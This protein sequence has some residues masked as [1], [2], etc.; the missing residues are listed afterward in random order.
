MYHSF[1][2]TYV[3][4][5]V[6]YSPLHLYLVTPDFVYLTLVPS[7]V[8]YKCH[9]G[10]F[11]AF[12]GHFLHSLFPLFMHFTLCFPLLL[13]CLF[14]HIWSISLSNLILVILSLQTDFTFLLCSFPLFS[15]HTLGDKTNEV[16]II[17]DHRPGQQRSYQQGSI[18]EE[19]YA[20]QPTLRESAERGERSSS[21]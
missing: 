15:D 4:R 9:S 20:G 13:L 5:P 2:F 17:G 7:R 6:S 1:V 3:L 19:A 14:R 21:G 11:F 18:D 16:V 10:I 8:H 12:F